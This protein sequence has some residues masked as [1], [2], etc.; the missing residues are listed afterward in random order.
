MSVCGTPACTPRSCQSFGA[1]CGS[2]GDGCGGSN[3][4]TSFYQFFP[5]A[6][7][8]DLANTQWS[9]TWNGSAYEF[10]TDVEKDIE[11]EIKN[12]DVDESALSKLLG[13][14]FF[15]DI[16]RDPNGLALGGHGAALGVRD[17]VGGVFEFREIVG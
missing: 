14:I 2:I 12:T 9:L 10:L 17:H 16:L 6:N 3:C 4:Q 11:V 13:E 1:T 7:Q 5:N 15:G 8:F